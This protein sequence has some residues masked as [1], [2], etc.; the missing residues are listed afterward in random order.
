MNEYHKMTLREFLKHVRWKTWR[1]DFQDGV[2]DIK[3]G[4]ARLFSG[5]GLV[6]LRAVQFPF[7]PIFKPIMGMKGLKT[8]R[9]LEA[10]EQESRGE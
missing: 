8:L 9:E 5:L 6:L 7:T 2:S 1:E 4:A 3:S 10:K